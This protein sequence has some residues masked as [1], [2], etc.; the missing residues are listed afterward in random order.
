MKPL[1]KGLLIGCGTIVLLGLISVG[2]IVWYFHTHGDEL[3]AQGKAVMEEG[4]RAGATATGPQCVDGG[5]D[6]YS[7]QRGF[8]GGI[9][10]RLWL[11]GCLRASASAREACVGV[12]AETDFLRSATWRVEQCDK[13][14]LSGDQT[15]PSILA[16]LQ[17]F[18]D[19][20]PS[21]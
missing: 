7:K 1:A 6:R 11:E 8:T 14:G 5:I 17:K 3:M 18:C 13:R 9:Q 15:C 20:K 21:R 16:G 4:A 19:E 10:S 12:P 2:A